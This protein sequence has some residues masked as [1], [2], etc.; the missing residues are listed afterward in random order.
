MAH[1]N[2]ALDV[3]DRQLKERFPGITI[4]WIADKAHSSTSD[5]AEDADGSVDALDP[6]I[7]D[8]FTAA[9]AEDVIAGLVASRDPRIGYIIWRGR[10]ISSTVAPWTWRPFLGKDPHTGH[11]H[12]SSR[13]DLEHNTFPWKI[14]TRKVPLVLAYEEFPVRMPVLKQGTTDADYPGYNLI[15]RVQDYFGLLQDGWYGDKTAAAVKGLSTATMKLDG[16][17]IDSRVYRIVFGLA[18]PVK[19]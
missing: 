2:P 15:V 10:I 5:H 11:F 9:D 8:A 18:W 4:G 1:R 17:T 14:T 12:I 13:Q 3:L 7:S 6:M 19:Q 16:K